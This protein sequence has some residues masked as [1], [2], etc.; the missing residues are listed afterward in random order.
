MGNK[1]KPKS[2]KEI[3][4]EVL[5][6]FPVPFILAYVF[7]IVYGFFYYRSFKATSFF[8]TGSYFNAALNLMKGRVDLFRT[9]VY[10]LFL[11]LVEKVDKDNI[12]NICMAVQIAVFYISIYF[13]FKTMEQ[14]TSNRV[15]LTVGTIIYGCMSPVITFNFYVLTESFAISGTTLFCYLIV[16]YAKKYKPGYLAGCIALTLFLTML[17]PSMVFLYVVSGIAVIPLI[18]RMFRKKQYGMNLVTVIAFVLSV[19]A[20]FGYMTKNKM[21]NNYFGLSYVSDMN[22]FYDV[23]QADIWRDNS[24]TLIVSDLYNRIEEGN[25]EALTAAIDSEIYNRDMAN[26]PYRIADFNK[27]AISKH[28]VEYLK[29]LIKKIFRMGSYN[30]AYNLTHDSYYLRD[31]ANKDIVWIGDFFDFNV[32]FSYLIC[33]VTWIMAASVLVERKK[34]LAGEFMISLMI[35]GQLAVNILT[36]PAEFHRLNVICYPLTILLTFACVGLALDRIKSSIPEKT[37]QN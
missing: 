1:K 27:E 2:A 23:V 30:T 3:K 37:K 34:L 28:K 26:D 32:N 15:M 9:P 25:T 31:E 4:A 21:D 36:G 8:D 14:F 12:A 20:L 29:F 6:V 35:A 33:L 17:R 11:H 13:F 19:S 18:V 24:N 5:S 22:R 16:I 10:P 7:D